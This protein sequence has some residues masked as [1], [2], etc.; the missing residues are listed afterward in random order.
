MAHT[1]SALKRVRQSEKR[2]QANMSVKSTVRSTTK[3]F[4]ATLEEGDA[5]KSLVT[6]RA[7][8]AT[9]SK[10][11]TKGVIRKQTASRRTSRL[12]RAAHKQSVAAGK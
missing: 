7:A 9:L 1:K 12:A 6:L 8:I 11:A 10:A 3:A 5:A 4:R 2:H